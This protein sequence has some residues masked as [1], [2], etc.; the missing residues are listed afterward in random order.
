MHN[1]IL[2]TFTKVRSDL[3]AK[4]QQYTTGQQIYCIVATTVRV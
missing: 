3:H 4:K 2:R 1:D